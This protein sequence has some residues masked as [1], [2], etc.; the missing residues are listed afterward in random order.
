MLEIHELMEKLSETLAALAEKSTKAPE[1][2][3]DLGTEFLENLLKIIVSSAQAEVL[4]MKIV[5][6]QESA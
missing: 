5:V 3:G 4:F 2:K 1:M 6:E